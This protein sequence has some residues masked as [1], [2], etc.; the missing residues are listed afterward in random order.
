MTMKIVL[1]KDIAG[2]GR[3]NDVK[4]VSDGYALNFLIPKKLATPGTPAIIAHAERMKSE[5]AKEREVQENLLFKNLSGVE[6]VKIELSCKASDKGHLFASIHKEAIV[7]ELKKQ[8][9]IDMLPEFLQLDKPIKE[10]GEH[11]IGVRV[12]DKTGGFTLVVTAA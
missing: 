1:L 5:Q 3:K 12:Q 6:G 10:V 2:V 7:A 4:N 11:K 8:T 9:R